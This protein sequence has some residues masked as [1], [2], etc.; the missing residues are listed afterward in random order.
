MT[1]DFVKAGLLAILSWLDKA[2][3]ATLTHID[4]EAVDIGRAIVE[5]ELLFDWF[6]ARATADDGALSI[7]AG[8][9]VALQA[10]LERRKIDWAKLAEVATTLITLYRMFRG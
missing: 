10:V 8:P 7:E 4:D 3:E 1:R 5:E 6:F 2:A 9:P